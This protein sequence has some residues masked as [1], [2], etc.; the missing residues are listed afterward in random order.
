MRRLAL[1]LAIAAF[2]LACKTEPPA[3]AKHR[4]HI[5]GT[6]AD[7]KVIP[8][9][10]QMSHCLVF[11]VADNG[12]V[13]QLTTGNDNKSL[14]CNAGEPISGAPFHATPVEGHIKVYVIFSDQEIEA[15]SIIEQIHEM[16]DHRGGFTAMDLRAP[17]AIAVE[18]LDY[19]P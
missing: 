12:V 11:S 7:F 1:V 14:A 18:T 13:H 15:T 6:G 8:E 19:K 4:A 3:A 5:E 10:G 2:A 17:G 9:P 16:I